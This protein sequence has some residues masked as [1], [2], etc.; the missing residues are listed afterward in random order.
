MYE[1]IGV[2]LPS[3]QTRL[4]KLFQKM[5]QHSEQMLCQRH[6]MLAVTALD[7]FTGLL[8]RCSCLVSLLDLSVFNITAYSS[9]INR[10]HILAVLKTCNC[11]LV[12]HFF[13]RSNYKLQ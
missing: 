2:C 7:D 4:P 6:Y 13:R 9:D 5:R 1:A 11:V 12:V 8:N 10:S 3:T